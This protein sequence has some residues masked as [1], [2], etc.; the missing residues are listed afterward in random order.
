MHEWLLVSHLSEMKRRLYR[1][2]S[3]LFVVLFKVKEI[4]EDLDKLRSQNVKHTKKVPKLISAKS[5][6]DYSLIWKF[7]SETCKGFKCFYGCI[8]SPGQWTD[9]LLLTGGL[10]EPCRFLS[11]SCQTLQRTE[12]PPTAKSW[13]SWFAS[14]LSAQPQQKWGKDLQYQ[15]QPSTSCRN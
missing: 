14:S 7:S 4:Q 11:T 13:G 12:C 10:Q 2:T 5:I 15:R 9:W 1:S 8:L 6:F 3:G